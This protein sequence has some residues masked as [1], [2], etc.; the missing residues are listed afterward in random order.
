MKILFE[1]LKEKERKTISSSAVQYNVLYSARLPTTTLHSI[2]PLTVT[3]YGSTMGFNYCTSLY[4]LAM[5]NCPHKR[6]G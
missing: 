1:V 5:P 6:L 3:K 4:L 2:D